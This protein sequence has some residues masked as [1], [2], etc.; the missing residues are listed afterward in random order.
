MKGKKL[1]LSDDDKCP[2]CRSE[3]V[4][5]TGGIGAKAFPLPESPDTKVFLYKC[6]TCNKE[7]DC[8]AE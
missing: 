3:F 4:F 8:E 2:H 1:L 7:F 6:Y 5:K